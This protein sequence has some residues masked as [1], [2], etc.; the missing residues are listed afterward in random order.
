MHGIRSAYSA[1]EIWNSSGHL[2]PKGTLTNFHMLVQWSIDS[3]IPR[4]LLQLL[5]TYYLIHVLSITIKIKGCANWHISIIS[6]GT[7]LGCSGAHLYQDIPSFL[8]KKKKRSFKVSQE[9]LCKITSLQ[10]GWKIFP[11]GGMKSKS[12]ACIVWC[13]EFHISHLPFSYLSYLLFLY[14]PLLWSVLPLLMSAVHW[15]EKVPSKS[16]DSPKL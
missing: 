12:D 11:S 16:F 10:A 6:K 15:H 2:F 14:I 9:N 4:S 7:L 8:G 13:A 3:S 5:V 1:V